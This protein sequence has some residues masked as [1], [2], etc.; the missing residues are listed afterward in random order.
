[1]RRLVGYAGW[2]DLAMHGTILTLFLGT[3]TMGLLQA[4]A[5]GIMVSLY[6]RLYRRLFGYERIVGARWVRYGGLL[7]GR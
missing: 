5:A 1:M 3:S 2:V 6:L 4:E 7:T